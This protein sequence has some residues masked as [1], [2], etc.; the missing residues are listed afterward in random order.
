[1]TETAVE[2]RW[3][4]EWLEGRLKF[5]DLTLSQRKALAEFYAAGKGPGEP[6]DPDT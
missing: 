6:V 2:V 4:V 3:F 5:E 1:M